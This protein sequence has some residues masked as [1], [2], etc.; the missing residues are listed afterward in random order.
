[1]YFAVCEFPNSITS[2]VSP[3]AIDASNFWRTESQL[4][5]CTFT[6]TPACCDLN[7][8][9]AF[10]TAA[11][12]PFCASDMSQTVMLEAEAFVVPP[13][14]VE[15]G[16]ASAAASATATMMR[17]FIDDPPNWLVNRSHRNAGECSGTPRASDSSSS[18]TVGSI[19]CTPPAMVVT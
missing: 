8:L 9:V 10:A 18:V 15:A 19:V 14:A 17:V 2:G 16:I 4:W 1:M 6:S 5:Y 12:Q 11:G 13:D 3:A 7:W